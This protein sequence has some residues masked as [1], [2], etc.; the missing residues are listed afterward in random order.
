[1]SYLLQSNPVARVLHIQHL[2]IA[3]KLTHRMVGAVAHML[4]NLRY[5]VV[6]LVREL[7]S[8]VRAVGACHSVLPFSLVVSITHIMMDVGAFGA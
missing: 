8:T 6:G 5:A 2:Q 7:R 4:L 3:L 1:M